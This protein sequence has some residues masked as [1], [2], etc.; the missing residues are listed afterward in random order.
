MP[1]HAAAALAYGPGL[2]RA[3]DEGVAAYIALWCER[4]GPLG[5]GWH[6]PLAVHARVRRRAIAT[7]LDQIERALPAIELAVG[8]APPAA[9][10]TDPGAQASY[11]AAEAF[12]DELAAAL[13]GTPRPGAFADAVRALADRVDRAAA[14]AFVRCS[15]R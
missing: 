3:V 9:M 1:S 2:S 12:A 4:E 14:A 8:A 7:Q 5:A 10:W 11:V 15:S 6:T 13:G